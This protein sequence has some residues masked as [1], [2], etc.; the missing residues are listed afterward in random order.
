MAEEKPAAERKASQLALVGMI[1]A[2]AG[3]LLV[4]LVFSTNATSIAMF[5]STAAVAG[6]VAGASAMAGALLGFLFG[7]PR[8]LQA[9]ERVTPETTT[10]NAS[11]STGP[12]QKAAYGANT[13]LE[14]IS[15]WLTKIL[16]GVGLTQLG[17]LGGALQS[18][19]AFIAPG[20]QVTG[21][22]EVMA[23]AIL[24][25]FSISGFLFGYLWTRL[26]MAGALR[27]ADVAALD[28]KI[29]DL[30]S[31]ITTDA[32]A[33]NL[34]EQQFAPTRNAPAATEED[35]QK[36]IANASPMM[37]TTILN[38]AWQIRSENWEDPRN[39]PVM[40]RTIPILTALAAIEDAPHEAHGQLGFALKDKRNPD[41]EGAEKELT[42]AIEMRGD[43]DS[44]GWEL[45]EF[46]RALCRVHLD[47]VRSPGQPASTPVR[48][49]ILN[50][51]RTAGRVPELLGQLRKDPAV[52]DWMTTNKV[53]EDELRKKARA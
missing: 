5:A 9:G 24:L 31:Q 46:N 3:G 19:T 43:V 15:D 30:E 37:K 29:S 42:R 33:L 10:S 22:P 45:Y 34:I 48:N 36:A 1:W 49:A 11:A 52:Q 50:D 38:R 17:N 44:R 14:Q 4:I 6:L 47:L 28:R 39:K 16:V 51:M 32:R 35:L 18:V 25:Y 7:I 53:T 27:E 41:W 8:A 26:Y 20:L 40:E 2:M 21:H 12:E 23:L 13:N